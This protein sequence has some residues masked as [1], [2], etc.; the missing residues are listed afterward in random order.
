MPLA[1][2]DEEQGTMRHD[3]TH[4]RWHLMLGAV[5]VAAG[6]LSLAGCGEEA[7]ALPVPGGHPD[8]GKHEL[9]AYGCGACHVIPGVRGAEGMVGPPL[10]QFARRTYIAGEAPNTSRYLVRWIMSPQ[11]IEPGTAMPN[12]G[13][14]EAEA[15]DMAAYLY[16]LR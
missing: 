2:G 16:T 15:R 8:R 4:A 7:K 12:L 9:A 14:P 1:S 13:V 3:M 11:S 6:G 5:L 10:A